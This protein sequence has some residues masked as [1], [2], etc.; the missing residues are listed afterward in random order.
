MHALD[1]TRW[2][3]D[4]EKL[5]DRVPSG[6]HFVGRSGKLE[7]VDVSDEQLLIGLVPV[8]P[9]PVA[10]DGFEANFAELGVTVLIPVGS[11]IL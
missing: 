10:A 9:G 11:A 5:T 3:G 4:F 7:I 2:F 8:N 1:V 6:L